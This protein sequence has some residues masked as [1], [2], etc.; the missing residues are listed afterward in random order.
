M[1][2][3]LS[4]DLDDDVYEAFSDAM[5]EY[6]ETETDLVRRLIHEWVAEQNE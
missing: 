2:T 4:V 6:E 1:T 3:E 5:N